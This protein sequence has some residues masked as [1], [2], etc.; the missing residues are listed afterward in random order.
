[1]SDHVHEH[2]HG[3][4]E[5][6]K[7]AEPAKEHGQDHGHGH[8]HSTPAA[9]APE[10]SGHSHGSAT[11]G[12]AHGHGTSPAAAHRPL[13][14]IADVVAAARRALSST[15]WD[16][17]FGGAET[18]TTI[19]RNRAALDALAVRGR[20]LNDVSVVSPG[21]AL[22]GAPMRIPV[23]LAPIGSL[24]QVTP[25]GTVASIAAAEA[26][27]TI[28]IAAGGSIDARRDLAGHGGHAVLQVYAHG[29]RGWLLD[30]ADL[31]AELG[32]LG[33]CL[34]AD[35]PWFGRR[36]RDLRRAEL[37]A[38]PYARSADG[39]PATW[40]DVEALV[41]RSRVPVIVKGI[42]SA[43]DA[44]AAVDRGAK[45]VYVSNHGGRQLDHAEASISVLPSVADAV[46]GRAQVIVDGGFLR[47]TDVVKAL[48]LGADAVA[49]GKLQAVGLAAAAERGL[50]NTLE[51][52]EDEVRTTMAL[53]GLASRAELAPDQV[54]P[55]PVV[56]GHP[57]PLDIF[58]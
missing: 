39:H 21:G 51:I 14:A 8:A 58:G 9:A 32:C 55:A 10:A 7:E 37:P 57:H 34:T 43:E 33:I 22:L 4:P 44:T 25:T 20:V 49:I 12:H 31:A 45:A 56:T 46:R 17:I 30:Q 50:V 47:G 19:R 13:P 26:F 40:A 16:S 23:V 48:A 38:G 35:V 53:M 29:D 28:V 36:E 11:G 52:L 42:L 3:R 1:M 54:R 27:G 6:A 41:A 2:D 15:V 24:R 18:E 5:P